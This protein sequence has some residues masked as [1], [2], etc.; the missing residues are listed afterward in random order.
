M[1]TKNLERLI[2]D[3]DELRCRAGE[4]NAGEIMKRI[5]NLARVAKLAQKELDT[6]KN[7]PNEQA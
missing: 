2:A 4:A 6:L 7:P 5:D 1:K 3:A